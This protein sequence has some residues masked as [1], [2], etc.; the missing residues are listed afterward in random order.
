[1]MC[2]ISQGLPCRPED[3]T[4]MIAVTWFSVAT[5]QNSSGTHADAFFYECQQIWA[6]TA[7]AQ[8]AL[9]HKFWWI[10]K[11][12]DVLQHPSSDMLEASRFDFWRFGCQFEYLFCKF[13]W[14]SSW[15]FEICDTHRLNDASFATN[16]SGWMM[17]DFI[18]PHCI[19]LDPAWSHTRLSIYMLSFPGCEG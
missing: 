12:S 10:V 5:L 9:Q 14:Y 2:L 7:L 19:P 18:G 17:P 15:F 8:K 11:S 16:G 6:P 4:N 3:R 13:H 1:M